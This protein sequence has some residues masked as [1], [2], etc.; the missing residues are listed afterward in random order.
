MTEAR[1]AKLEDVL[2]GDALAWLR[3]RLRDRLA[4]G[5]SLGSI[6]RLRNPR[7]DQRQ[8][9]ER[10]LGVPG[11]T[12]KHLA[13]RIDDLEAMITNL[14]F[15][16]LQTALAL[17]EGP[18]VSPAQRKAREDAVWQAL[19][20]ECR[21]PLCATGC[22]PEMIDGL[23]ANGLLRRI[24]G[25]YPDEAREILS[26]ALRVMRRLNDIQDEGTRICRTALS[27]GLFGDS[28]ALDSGEAVVAV[29]KALHGLADVDDA[30]YW[31]HVSVVCDTTASSALVLNLRFRDGDLAGAINQYAE[32]G[33]PCR[34]TLNTIDR[35]LTP[36]CRSVYVCENPSV[37]G[38]ASRRHGAKGKPIVCT[39]GQPSIACQRILRM[40]SDQGA[41]I[42]YHGDFD[43]GGIRIGNFV[44]RLCDGFTPW[45]YG[46]ED[47]LDTKG[48]FPLLGDPVESVWDAGLFRSM[49]AR[50]V[51]VHEEMLL[52]RLLADV[53]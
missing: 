51:G 14:G 49:Q 2:G 45:R 4:R 12:G 27:A 31:S 8:A 3:K 30:A 19:L 26:R 15:D 1:K 43:W 29:L 39:E 37:L 10:L 48:G 17:L 50:R 42:H 28:H 46:N 18:I 20:E 33:E 21:E 7:P 34:I 24:S 44:H 52:E 35:G 11:E 9:V 6:A 40:L 32:A 47:Y 22:Q 23:L 36:N 25:Q 38:E 53:I 5:A 13:V 16:S 41:H